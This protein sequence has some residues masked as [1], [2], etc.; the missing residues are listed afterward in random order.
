[1]YEFFVDLDEKSKLINLPVSFYYWKRYFEKTLKEFHKLADADD[2]F[3]A[4]SL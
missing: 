1:M 4:F 3:K 2:R